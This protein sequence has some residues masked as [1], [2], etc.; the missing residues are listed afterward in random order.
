[1]PEQDQALYAICLVIEDQITVHD[2]QAAMTSQAAIDWQVLQAVLKEFDLHNDISA[3]TDTESTQF[4]SQC[5]P[6]R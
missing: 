3:V 6:T 4:R 2:L 1:M 5:R